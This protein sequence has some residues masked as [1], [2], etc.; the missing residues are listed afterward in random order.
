MYMMTARF[1][2]TLDTGWMYRDL[3]N[4]DRLAQLFHPN[5]TIEVTWFEGLA[6]D[7]IEGSIKMGKSDLRTKHFVGQPVVR[8]NGQ[9][10][11]VETKCDDRRRE[12]RVIVLDEL[13]C[14]CID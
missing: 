1:L 9:R 12:R 7:F 11:I 2:E 5:G 13:V 14:E 10:A 3:A 6:E 8:I 4:R